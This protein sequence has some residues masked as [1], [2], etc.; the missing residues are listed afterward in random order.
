MSDSEKP[1]RSRYPG[2]VAIRHAVET[3]RALGI[4]VAGF[5]VSPSGTIR[6]LDARTMPQQPVTLYDQLKASGQL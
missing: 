2:R 6:I 4:D 1:S 5:E 3:A